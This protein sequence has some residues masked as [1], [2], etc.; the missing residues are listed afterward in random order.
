M[1]ET[2]TRSIADLPDLEILFGATGTEMVAPDFAQLFALPEPMARSGPRRLIV[3]RNADLRAIAAHPASGIN[4][5][6]Q[7]DPESLLPAEAPAKI[8]A[9]LCTADA[10]D[11]PSGENTIR[12]DDLRRRAGVE[13]SF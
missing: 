6:S 4:P 11:L 12:D 1:S 7:L 8:I 10:A 3:F 5:V 9:Y 13:L 2:A